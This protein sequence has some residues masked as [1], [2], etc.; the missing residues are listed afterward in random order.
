MLAASKT[1]PIKLFSALEMPLSSTLWPLNASLQRRWHNHLDPN[2]KR[3]DWSNK[4]DQTLVEK[5][6][7]FGNQWAKI[8][9]FLPGR[10]DNSI[11]NH[12]NSTMKRKVETGQ[13]RVSGDSSRRSSGAATVASEARATAVSGSSRPGTRGYKHMHSNYSGSSMRTSLSTSHS[14][15][16]LED[17]SEWAGQHGDFSMAGM[18]DLD[19]AD[20]DA[21]QQLTELSV[22]PVPSPTA[23][24]TT[25]QTAKRSARACA[26]KS[27]ALDPPAAKSASPPQPPPSRP[28][29]RAA[30]GWALRSASGSAD[31]ARQGST[32]LSG[33]ASLSQHGSAGEHVL[34]SRQSGL[35]TQTMWHDA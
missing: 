29:T 28:R 32:Q 3:G 9:Q 13:A 16:S 30:A 25:L 4:E 23:V 12:W 6:A 14:V 34:F 27:R 35:L 7:E 20:C 5:H 19:A 22:S 21:A 1:D 2:I 11:K 31:M 18:D 26:R 17:T 24:Q 8:A 10:T 33:Q 15:S